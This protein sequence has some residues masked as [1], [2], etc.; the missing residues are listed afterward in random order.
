MNPS[1]LYESEGSITSIIGEHIITLFSVKAFIAGKSRNYLLRLLH[2]ASSI[3]LNSRRLITYRPSAFV[4]R[5][6]MIAA[7]ISFAIVS[8]AR[9]VC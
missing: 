5:S 6:L 2:R 8:T 9:R 3:S 4:D 7:V 1:W